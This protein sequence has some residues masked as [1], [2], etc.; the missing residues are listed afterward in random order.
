M[1]MPLKTIVSGVR[2]KRR[3][4]A[5]GIINNEVI[6]SAPTNFILTAM[7]SAV[8]IIRIKRILAIFIPST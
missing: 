8:N 2:E 1:N 6:I 7:V 5:A 4:V 3:A